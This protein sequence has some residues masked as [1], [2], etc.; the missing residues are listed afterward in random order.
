MCEKHRDIGGTTVATRT[1]EAKQLS[2][3]PQGVS[4]WVADGVKRFG[5]A[6]IENVLGKK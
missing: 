3:N 6:A 4:E 5:R 2:S 1:P